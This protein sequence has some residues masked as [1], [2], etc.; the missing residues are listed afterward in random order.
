M[1]LRKR[2]DDEKPKKSKGNGQIQKTQVAGGNDRN[3]QT[4][5]VTENNMQKKNPGEKQS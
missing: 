5:D 1:R 4:K 3:T 2:S